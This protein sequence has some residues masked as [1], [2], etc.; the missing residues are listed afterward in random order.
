MV[1]IRLARGGA[2]KRPFY[3]MVVAYALSRRDCRF[4]EPPWK[5]LLSN[6]GILPILWELYPDHPSL[7][8]AFRDAAPLGSNYVRKPVHSRE[9]ANIAI[10]EN[11]APV[12]SESGPYGDT[13]SICQAIARTQPVDGNWPVLGLWIVDGQP[14]GMGIREDASRITGNLSRFVPHWFE[15]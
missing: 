9:G 7:L 4:L 1:V 2:K 14:A 3:N 5:L 15:G 12:V 13:G 8:P 10:I 11:G 6:K